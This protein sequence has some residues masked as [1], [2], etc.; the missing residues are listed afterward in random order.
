V[1]PRMPSPPPSVSPAIPT[2]GQEPAGIA[3]SSLASPA[4]ISPRRAP[5]PTVAIPSEA[6]TE[7]ISLRSMRSPRVAER[8]AKQCP[9][10]RGVTSQ[11][12]RRATAIDSATSV[13]VLQRT[14]ASGRTFSYCTQAGFVTD[15]YV[16]ESGRITSP[17]MLA[18]STASSRL[19]RACRTN[20][21]GAA[22]D[23]QVATD[24][25][26]HSP[27]YSSCRRIQSC[28]ASPSSRPLGAWSRIG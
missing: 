18:S 26:C 23:G 5:A 28:Q 2:A 21:C 14:T 24:R 13:G 25:A 17:S 4:S 22:D 12:R 7:L 3:S 1:R 15:P 6:T 16:G 20:R 27:S 10:P 11:P 8:P 9:P 19:T